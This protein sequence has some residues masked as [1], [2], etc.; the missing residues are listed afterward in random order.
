MTD[1]QPIETAPLDGDDIDLW[2]VDQDGKG[3]RETNARYVRNYRDDWIVYDGDGGHHYEHGPRDG[4]FAP[5]H[6][7]DGQD[8]FC[9]QPV[10]QYGRPLRDTWIKPTHWMPLPDP[11]TNPR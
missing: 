4:W 5:N 10:R 8:G 11:P 2:M 7:Y 1:W 9:D 6:D 3:W